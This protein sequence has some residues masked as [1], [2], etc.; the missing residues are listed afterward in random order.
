MNRWYQKKAPEISSINSK[1]LIHP[2]TVRGHKGL[3]INPYQGC[4]HRCAY[5]YATYEWSPKFYDKIYAKAN[6][7][8]VL[9]KQL[10]SL[11]LDSVLP[12]MVSSATDAYQPAEIRYNL[13]RRCIEILQR[14]QIPYYVFTKSIIILRDLRLHEKYKD[15]CCLIWS[16]TTC[17]EK[18]RR[19]VEPG[20]PPADN[21]FKIIKRFSEAGVCCGVNID[22]ILPLITDSEGELESIIDLCILSGVKYVHASILRLRQD[23]WER[24]KF[25]IKELGICR[26]ITEY[27]D[28]IYQFKS[29]LNPKFSLVAREYYS[30]KVVQKLKDILVKNGILF[31]F[32]SLI[33]NAKNKSQDISNSSNYYSGQKTLTQYLK[34]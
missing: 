30:F 9:S 12:V 8:E 10:K 11:K 4:Q 5:C 34:F 6:A 13:T 27:Q 28:K 32:P 19:L 21:I 3:T 2:F 7:P 24:M 31:E 22:P 16:I 25:V 18:I 29:P 15:K 26:G 23:I 17:N 33:N 14:H 20:T 1:S